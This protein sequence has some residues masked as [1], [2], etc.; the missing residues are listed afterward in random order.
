MPPKNRHQLISAFREHVV[1]FSDFFFPRILFDTFFLRSIFGKILNRNCRLTS[2]PKKKKKSHRFFFQI[3]TF[4]TGQEE[5]ENSKGKCHRQFFRAAAV[6]LRMHYSFR[7]CGEFEPGNTP[8][9]PNHPPQTHKYVVT[10]AV[11]ANSSLVLYSKS[12]TTVGRIPQGR[13][14]GNRTALDLPLFLQL[15]NDSRIPL[16]N[17]NFD[18]KPYPSVYGI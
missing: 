2:A 1:G 9:P 8:P 3:F 13:L 14:R 12:T 15:P 11:V 4:S 5:A 10:L 6:Y 17:K 16:N 7:F 18:R